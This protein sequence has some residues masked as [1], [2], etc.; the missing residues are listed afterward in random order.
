[1]VCVMRTTIVL[2]D[3]VIEE[4]REHI[5]AGSLSGFVREAVELR[6]AALRRASLIRE[7]E[8][9]YA[10]EAEAPSLDP[11]WSEIETEGIE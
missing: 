9:G 4:V 8:T 5:G 2:P 7:M 11:E 10:A 1:M 6:L 3:Q